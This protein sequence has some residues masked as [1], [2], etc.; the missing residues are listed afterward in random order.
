MIPLNWKLRL[1]PCHFG[2]FMPLNQQAKKGVMV[3][4][5][6][7]DPDYQGEIGLLL[8]GGSEEECVWN[9]G[10]ALVLPCL[11]VKVN[12]KLQ[13]TNPS[14]TTNGPDPSGV[15]VRVTLPA[16]EQ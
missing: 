6:V 5:G 13:Q 12:G 16:K 8:H 2:L 7:I 3:L 9:T 1:P 11:V 14:K 15:K 10:D 4:S